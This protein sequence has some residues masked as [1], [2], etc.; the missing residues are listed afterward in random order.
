MVKLFVK[1]KKTKDII[2]TAWKE[3]KIRDAD[4]FIEL[5][6]DNRVLEVMIPMEEMKVLFVKLKDVIGR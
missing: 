3:P 6:Y 1:D 4:V 5:P 2:K